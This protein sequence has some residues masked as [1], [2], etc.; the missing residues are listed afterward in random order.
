MLG[1][2]RA[3]NDAYKERHSKANRRRKAALRGARQ[4]RRQGRSRHRDKSESDESDDSLF[5]ARIGLRDEFMAIRQDRQSILDYVHSKGF[6]NIVFERSSGDIRSDGIQ[7]PT[8]RPCP[9]GA[10]IDAIRQM[11]LPR[12]S[13]LHLSSK[14]ALATAGCNPNFMC[15]VLPSFEG[16][17]RHLEKYDRCDPPP[18]PNVQEFF[19]DIFGLFPRGEP[20][21]EYFN[22]I[23]E[24][25]HTEAFRE[26]WSHVLHKN[27]GID[28]EKLCGTSSSKA[29]FLD[30]PGAEAVLSHSMQSAR[31][32]YFVPEL[33][34]AAGRAKVMPQDSFVEI[35]TEWLKE[36]AKARSVNQVESEVDFL[37]S[38]DDDFPPLLEGP[39]QQTQDQTN[40]APKDIK[41]KTMDRLIWISPPSS[42]HASTPGA[43]T[44]ARTVKQAQVSTYGLSPFR[45]GAQNL[46]RSFGYLGSYAPTHMQRVL[47]GVGR[48]ERAAY[49]RAMQRDR[50]YHN[51]HLFGM[52][53]D[54]RRM[55]SSMRRWWINIWGKDAYRDFPFGEDEKRN[56]SQALI[57]AHCGGKLAMD[58]E[59]I[60]EVEEG[61][62]TGA[63]GV[64]NLE[65]AYRWIS[66][67]LGVTF[68]LQ[69]EIVNQLRRTSRR[70][71]RVDERTVDLA[72]RNHGL[73]WLRAKRVEYHPTNRPTQLGEREI[74]RKLNRFALN[75]ALAQPS[76]SL[77]PPLGPG[78]PLFDELL[79]I[80]GFY[81]CTVANGDDDW[82]TFP[83]LEYVRL[84]ELPSIL[85]PSVRLRWLADSP[86]VRQTPEKIISNKK[87]GE[88]ATMLGLPTE[89]NSEKGMEGRGL[90]T[91]LLNNMHPLW[92]SF[93]KSYSFYIESTR[94]KDGLLGLTHPDDVIRSPAHSILRL[95]GLVFNH[96]DPRVYEIF[97][98]IAKELADQHNLHLPGGYLNVVEHLAKE[99]TNSLYNVMG[100][101]SSGFEYATELREG[102][103]RFPEYHE[104]LEHHGFSASAKYVREN[105]YT[106]EHLL[107]LGFPQER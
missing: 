2:G 35:T 37:F 50:A 66:D 76:Y 15:T 1:P 27:S 101:G 105:A 21:I 102:R 58:G 3:R 70:G 83:F 45:G 99:K 77:Y 47:S 65:S 62:T 31:G 12:W 9:D 30:E 20:D 46:Y 57:D 4:P 75:E 42:L 91:F 86:K 11:S 51:A 22:S 8:A 16:K 34:R 5:L 55:D 87:M 74:R 85:E 100:P 25:S 104:V 67:L 14:I 103:V 41:S 40:S 23:D 81:Y 13:E 64:S 53:S 38:D 90:E 26:R 60:A 54:V 29:A 6:E 56:L 10:M 39:S 63:V 94:L 89:L 52:G 82:N 44:L 107:N 43:R 78:T 80:V 73:S 36:R 7:A 106:V 71:G 79:P 84:D 59:L 69:R 17:L 61:A 95:V 32:G 88:A 18:P 33:M 49:H 24:T 97:S 68:N 19:S 48:S 96:P 93:D 92:S 72:G 28:G 98:A